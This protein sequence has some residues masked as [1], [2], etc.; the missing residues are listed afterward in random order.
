MRTSLW[1]HL[2]QR[3][4][5]QPATGASP[6]VAHC[7]RCGYSLAMLPLAGRCP[8]CG[9]DYDSES[10]RLRIPRPP[11]GAGVLLLAP[12][13]ILPM[14]VV[15]FRYVLRSRSDVPGVAA[16]LIGVVGIFAGAIAS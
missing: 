15:A 7:P 14:L 6:D 12:L 8:E 5:L 9:D 3:L 13:L 10:A 2:L 1:A 4:R 16:F 11:F